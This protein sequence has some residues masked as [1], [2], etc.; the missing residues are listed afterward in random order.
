MNQ[1]YVVVEKAVDTKSCCWDFG[2]RI[3]FLYGTDYYF[4][5]AIG[6]ETHG[7]GSQKWN[8]EDGPRFQFGPA[9][10][11]GIALPQLYAEVF[12]PIGNGLSI[13]LGHFYTTMGYESVMSTANFFYS[14]AI[15][16]QYFEPF[17]HTGV[18]ATYSLSEQ[19]KVHAG[20]TRGWETWDDNNENCSFMAG[21]NWTSCDERASLFYGVTFGD[22]PGLVVDDDRFYQSVY[23]TY[24]VTDR[25]TSVTGSDLIVQDNGSVN[26]IG[27]IDDSEAYSLYQ[28][29]FYEINKCV[30]A[31][32]R[33]EWSRDDD[34]ARV[35]PVGGLTDGSN[36]FSL[37]TGVNWKLY[38]NLLLRPELRWDW[39]DFGEPGAR[40]Y[41]DFS[42][43]NQ[44]TAAIS[45][46]LTF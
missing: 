31:G 5:T 23:F 26:G 45:A 3:D 10:M 38:D 8:S 36:Y 32:V 43:S 33:V 34:N 18:L 25:L 35:I 1:F 22:E 42:D 46:L 41:D 19:L 15:T 39:S 2:G 21:F 11:Y 12:A 44:F 4:T 37:T 14:H 24:K 28:Y 13:K 17:T 29:L 9:A 16:H 27:E 30:K 40:A 6:L 7:D 20:L